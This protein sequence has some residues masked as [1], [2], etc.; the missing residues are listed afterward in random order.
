MKKIKTIFERDW[1]GNRG[2]IDCYVE[3]LQDKLKKATATEKIDGMNVRVTVRNKTF[4]R[5][6]KRRNPNKTQKQ[7]GITEPWYVDANESDPDDKYIFD[8]IKST[9]LDSIPDGEFNGELVGPK[10]QG[11]P[12]K[13][14]N[15]RIVFFTLGQCPVFEDAPTDFDGLREWLPKQKSKYGN[16]CG[17]EG[18]VW[19]CQDGEMFKI[20]CKD[21]K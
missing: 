2:V 13:L 4:V 8:G 16:D 15:H 12:L 5:I 9:N 11:N 19:H 6:E 7:K 14:K 20:K 1:D 21:F 3:S 10:V 17:I 18:I